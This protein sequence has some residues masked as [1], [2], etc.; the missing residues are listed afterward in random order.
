MKEERRRPI[1]DLYGDF[2]LVAIAMR[3]NDDTDYFVR[4]KAS[5]ERWCFGYGRRISRGER[6]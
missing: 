2:H 6:K 4:R 3:L 5:L 1:V